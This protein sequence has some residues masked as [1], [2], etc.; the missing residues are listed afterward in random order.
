[1][2]RYVLLALVLLL[3][4]CSY[5]EAADNPPALPTG[6][7]CSPISIVPEAAVKDDA[8]EDGLGAFTATDTTPEAV[9]WLWTLPGC[10][11]QDSQ[12]RTFTGACP[13][14]ETVSWR[15]TVYDVGGCS[16]STSGN[17]SFS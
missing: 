5:K 12:R 3:P 1:M 11:P 4:A 2:K 8:S 14:G 6:P 10:D 17:T 13:V 7:S 9:G 15:L 16:Y